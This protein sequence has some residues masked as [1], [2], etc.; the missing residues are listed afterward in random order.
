MKTVQSTRRHAASIVAIQLFYVRNSDPSYPIKHYSECL[1][2]PVAWLGVLAILWFIN[3]QIIRDLLTTNGT[4][5][6]FPV[7]NTVGA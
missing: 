7:L 5:S 4:F 2:L 6:D 1:G 3:F